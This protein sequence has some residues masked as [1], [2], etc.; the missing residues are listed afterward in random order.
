MKSDEELIA[1]V[2]DGDADAFEALYY[3]Y[4][5][6]VY[7]LAWRFTRNHADAL[8]VVQ[9]T[10]GYLLRKFPGFELTA[11][12]TTFLYPVVKHTSFAVRR[13]SRRVS[14]DDEVLDEIP[15]PAPKETSRR[16]LAA[17]LGVLSDE[18]REVLMMKYLDDMSLKEIAAALNI[19]IGTVKSRLHQ[20][21]QRLRDDRRTR[22]Y[23]LE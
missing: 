3:R 13:K 10:F 18:Q 22:D 16:E 5:D 21:V 9:D 8:D 17:V 14:S 23:F 4:R 7:R 6:W 11:S 2:N 20:A 15:A 1:L 19:P 12:M